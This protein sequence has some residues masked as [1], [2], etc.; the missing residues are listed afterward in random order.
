MLV[1]MQVTASLDTGLALF[2]SACLV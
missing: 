2:S 1:R